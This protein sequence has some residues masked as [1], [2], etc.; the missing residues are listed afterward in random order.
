[1]QR[2]KARGISPEYKKTRAY[3]DG[4]LA[5]RPRAE[6]AFEQAQRSG[7]QTLSALT[8]NGYTGELNYGH[9]AI[10]DI[11]LYGYTGRG[12]LVSR[13]SVDADKISGPLFFLLKL[14]LRLLS[15]T[16]YLSDKISDKH[17][18]FQSLPMWAE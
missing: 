18:S 6:Q 5:H 7:T 4:T 8:A 9:T 16:K 14:Q 10:T 1:L 2:R 12:Y 17:L 3:L 15:F 11:R 13:N